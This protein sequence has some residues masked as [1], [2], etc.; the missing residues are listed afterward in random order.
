[1]EILAVTPAVGNLIRDGKTFQIPGLMQVGKSHGMLLLDDSLEE[2]LSRKLIS[3]ET[4][5]SLADNPERFLGI[6]NKEK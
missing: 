2:L 3:K 5:I 4:A 6:G 1:M